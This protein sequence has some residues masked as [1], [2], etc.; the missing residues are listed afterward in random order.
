MPVGSPP[1]QA[2]PSG[3]SLLN[4]EFIIDRQLSAGGF[5]ITYLAQDTTL[6][7]EIVI[8]ECFPEAFSQRIGLDVHPSRPNHVEQY[9]TIVGTFIHE[10]RSIAGIRH[11]NIVGVHRVFE[12]NSTAYMALD[13]IKGR[14]LLDTIEEKSNSLTPACVEAILFKLL[15]AVA[16][17]HDADMLHRDI[18]PDNILIDQ[19]D[20][21]ILIDFGAARGEASKKTRALSSLLVVKDGYSPPEFY[22]A[23]SVQTANSDLYS[24]GATFYHLISGEAPTISQNRMA[25]LAAENPDPCLPLAGRFP[26]YPDA[27]LKAIDASMRVL[28]KKRI[29]SAREWLQMMAP[30][31]T[32]PVSR[33]YLASMDVPTAPDVLDKSITRLIAETNAH[34]EKSK[35]I[36]PK[37]QTKVA[38]P[39]PK[40]RVV[41]PE[42]IEEF[43]AETVNPEKPRSKR[44]AEDPKAD[45]GPNWIMRALDKQEAR[46]VS[47]AAEAEAAAAPTKKSKPFAV[48]VDGQDEHDETLYDQIES[49]INDDSVGRPKSKSAATGLVLILSAL[50]IQLSAGG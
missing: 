14:D 17:V 28:P 26:A 40:S 13:L 24:L 18:A 3:T 50:A 23:G 36:D 48:M 20:N 16:T 6:K 7:R 32:H 9:K 25:E 34:V 4:G 49:S 11:P 45:A 10:A 43:N 5:G 39:A 27:F 19:S 35:A 46:R 30:T 29:Q 15:D 8:K 38:P 47:K 42:W 2:L 44:P 21:P 31:A 33:P 41:Q 37:P 12:Q 22:L 1:S